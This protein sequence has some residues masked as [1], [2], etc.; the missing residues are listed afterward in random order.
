MKTIKKE[1]NVIRERRNIKNIT[2][3]LLNLKEIRSE[4]E[5]IEADKSALILGAYRTALHQGRF[6]H[7]K[8]LSQLIVALKTF[9]HHISQINHLISFSSTL[10]E[11]GKN[12]NCDL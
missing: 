6:R 2:I 12:L 4:K 1:I 9:F 5:R 10:L 11:M 3:L 8:V 7:G